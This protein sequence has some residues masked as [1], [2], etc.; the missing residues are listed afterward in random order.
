[1]I[2]VAD[3]IPD[4]LRTIVEFLNEQLT[5]IEVLAVEVKRYKGD[6]LTTLVSSMIGNTA[7]AKQTKGV[8]ARRNQDRQGVLSGM[9]A[10]LGTAVRAQ[11][12]D[13]LTWAEAR[14]ITIRP[15]SG[16]RGSLLLVLPGSDRGFLTLYANGR[17]FFD[18][19]RHYLKHAPFDDPSM[20]AEL[21]NKLDGLK[22]GAHTLRDETH[23]SGYPLT[24]S[25]TDLVS[26]P[27]R[28]NLETLLDWVLDRMQLAPHS[29]D[30]GSKP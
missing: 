28:K 9:E 24:I 20:K 17:V 8:S 27:A 21:L 2:F 6:G 23:I 19:T 4:E 26:P 15:G 25:V 22:P 10:E 30:G 14:R 29:T 16:Q 3:K 12:E 7:K 18:Q 13:L 1:L 5:E 11:V